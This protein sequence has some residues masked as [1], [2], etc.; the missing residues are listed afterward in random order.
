MERPRGG[1]DVREVVTKIIH[2]QKCPYCG[3]IGVL[4]RYKYEYIT[5]FR[6]DCI[7]CGAKGPPAPTAQQAI[8]NWTSRDMAEG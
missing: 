5:L 8:A 2:D 7:N 4:M 1:I 6:V 3:C